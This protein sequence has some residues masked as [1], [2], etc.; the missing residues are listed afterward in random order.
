[1]LA[2]LLIVISAPLS[3][4]SQDASPILDRS[5]LRRTGD[6]DEMRQRRVIRVLVTHNKTNF[7]VT[8]G[9]PRGF[10]FELFR[11]YEK[12]L[13]QGRTRREVKVTLAFLPVNKSELLPFLVQGKG[14]I[15]AA[16][17]TITPDRQRQAAFTDPYLKD[18]SEIVVAGKKAAPLATVEDLSGKAV[19]VGAASSYAERLREFNRLLAASGKAPVEIVE[20]PDYL[21]TEDILE[22][23]NA[24]IVDYTLAD[25]YLA[26][27]WS[28]VLT[29][30]VLRPDLAVH[31][32]SGI[33]W[34]VRHGNPQLL[35]SLNAFVQQNRKG[36][37]LGNILFKR[38]YQ[39]TKW[40]GN[41][42]SP[43]ARQRLDGFITLFKKYGDR[44][45]LDWLLIAALAYQESGLNP[46]LT[47]RAGAV[48]LMQVQPSTAEFLGISQ[49]DQVENNIH[50]GVKYLDWL[51]KN[52]FNDSAIPPGAKVDFALASYNAG[53]NRMVRLRRKASEMGHDPN[54]WFHNVE[55][56]ALREVGQETVRYVANV[57]KYYFAFRLS[58]D[59]LQK[60]AEELERMKKE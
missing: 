60:R 24:G 15:A 44:Y 51:R 58:R 38:Y 21:E 53:P 28:G 6:L 19:C 27:L 29:D 39:S 54:R 35:A 20:A 17:L 49:S 5:E 8:S 13:N 43:A 2:I 7:F 59:I 9:Q 34:A 12:F 4:H 1:M 55:H 48:G 52:Y 45:Q 40:I 14:D 10:E 56:A 3:A 23:V 11:E 47:S 32:G 16:A 33:G 25:Q 31:S 36:T 41:P 30:M 42:L 37:L 22:L 26:E 50:A 18:V 46:N 57:N